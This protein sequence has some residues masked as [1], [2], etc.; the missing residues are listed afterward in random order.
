MSKKFGKIMLIAAAVSG[1]AATAAV[2]LRKREQ[3]F[4]DSNKDEDEYEDDFCE[5]LDDE[6]DVPTRSYVPLTHP[7]EPDAG[8]AKETDVPQN[9]EEEPAKE[10]PEA[11]ET[12]QPGQEAQDADALS[13]EADKTAV[14][15]EEAT[16]E[17]AQA[18]ADVE[19]A[20]MEADQTA[21]KL[22]ETVEEFFDE[23]DASDE[24]PPIID[25]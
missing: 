12:E 7:Q 9:A 3:H 20:A 21:D 4:T 14:D 13:I 11:E 19:T 22:E 6:N 8:E 16:D 24:E 18:A 10:A 2:L 1:V 5:D 17:A 23:D 25:N 15:V